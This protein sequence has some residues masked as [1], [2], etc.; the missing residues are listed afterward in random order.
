MPTLP[1]IGV[2]AGEG[3]APRAMCPRHQPLLGSFVANFRI[4]SVVF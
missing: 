3:L 2:G 4:V 1:R